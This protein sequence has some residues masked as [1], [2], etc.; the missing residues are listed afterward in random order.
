LKF[1]NEFGLVIRS[2]FRQGTEVVVSI[3][4]IL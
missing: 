1:G 2:V 3:P 4:I